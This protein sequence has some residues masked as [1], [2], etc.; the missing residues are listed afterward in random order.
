MRGIGFLAR[1]RR[2]TSGVAMLEFGL[3]LPLFLGFLLAGI[4]M[5]N[6]VMANNRTQRLAAMTA[7][8][9]AQSGAGSIGATESQIY[10]LFSAIDLTAQPFDLRRHGRVVITAVKGTDQNSDRII[11]N[12]IMWQRFDGDY[13][14]AHPVLGCHQTMPLATLPG[15]RQLSLDELMFHVQVTYQY[16]PV[17][18]QV[19]FEMFDVPG[20]FTRYAMFRA[21]SNQFQSP[22]P[23]SGYPAKSK[24][25]SING[26]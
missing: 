7:D 20:D 15:N 11:E 10:D 22:T 13:V 6:Y 8:L 18:S 24:C 26:L 12:R 21:R 3:T 25:N 2:N 4:E 5:G 1:L 9:V 17:F 14:A 23:E 19:P 16:Q